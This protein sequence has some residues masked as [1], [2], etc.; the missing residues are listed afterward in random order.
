MASDESVTKHAVWFLLAGA[1]LLTLDSGPALAGPRPV[2]SAPIIEIL[3]FIAIAAAW[4]LYRGDAS[5]R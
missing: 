1:M 5:A 3:L 2:Q 4:V